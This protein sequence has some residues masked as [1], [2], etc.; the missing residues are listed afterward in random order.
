M[1]VALALV[2]LFITGCSASLTSCSR[3]GSASLGETTTFNYPNYDACT[4][5]DF[6][7]CTFYGDQGANTN[8]SAT[9]IYYCTA[10]QVMNVGGTGLPN[11]DCDC[12]IGSYCQVEMLGSNAGTWGTCVSYK[13]KIG[14]P[15]NPTLTSVS[16]Q[17]GD[18]KN[19]ENSYC[20]MSVS[21]PDP[22]A[23]GVV[24]YESAWEG[25]CVEGICRECD[26]RFGLEQYNQYLTKT[27]FSNDGQRTAYCT[28][29]N[30]QKPRFCSGMAWKTYNSASTAAASVFTLLIT[31]ALTLFFSL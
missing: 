4:N 24:D 26:S 11:A 14:K 7:F 21:F 23:S 9:A 5:K 17:N 3:P 13:T 18:Y 28:G 6:P 8:P 30:Y 15:C 19:G 10:C 12:D 1:F 16:M 27:G 25:Y 31:L 20:G 29:S 22:V 2:A